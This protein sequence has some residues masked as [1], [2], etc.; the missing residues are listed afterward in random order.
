M[1]ELRAASQADLQDYELV[2]SGAN[3]SP[4]DI[5]IFSKKS[6]VDP[7]KLGVQPP[8]FQTADRRMLT[9]FACRADGETVAMTEKEIASLQVR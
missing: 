4:Q 2:I 5:V 3:E 1:A 9:R 8:P 6:L 7:W